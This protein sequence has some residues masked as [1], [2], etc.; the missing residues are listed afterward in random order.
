MKRI[1]IASILVIMLAAAVIFAGCTSPSKTISPA[2]TPTTPQG[3]TITVPYGED[4]KVSLDAP[5]TTEVYLTMTARADSRNIGGGRPFM[6]LQ[7]NGKEITAVRLVNKDLNFT[8]GDGF[9]ASYWSRNMSAWYLFFSPDFLAYEDP[10]YADR[11]LEGN[12]YS[13]KFDVSDIVNKGAPNEV[14]IMNIGDEAAAQYKNPGDIEYYKSAPIVASP[15]RFEGKGAGVVKITKD[16]SPTRL[17]V[18]KT[19]VVSVTITNNLPGTITDIE[20][21]DS[22]VP[23]GLSGKPMNGKLEKHL[24]SGQSYTFTYD[25]TAEKKGSYTLG[26]VTATF[27]DATGNYQKIS[28]GTVTITVI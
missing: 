3:Q 5:A 22:D 11:I 6:R 10:T 18:G 23:Q 8:Y 13:Y 24:T 20:V 1:V 21:A 19:S 12:A 15:V 4:V 14:V 17:V 7:V 16:A 26:A 9:K 27:A 25:V 2:T 28:S